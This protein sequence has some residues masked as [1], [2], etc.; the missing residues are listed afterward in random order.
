MKGSLKSKSFGELVNPEGM[1]IL[2]ERIKRLNG[3]FVNI[4]YE[5]SQEKVPEC[6]EDLEDYPDVSDEEVTSRV[7]VLLRT[8]KD[9]EQ[10]HRKKINNI[11]SYLNRRA[12]EG[13]QAVELINFYNERI[14]GFLDDFVY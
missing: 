2:K 8:L 4:A 5:V 6:P 12:A 3:E 10:E 11:S 9:T 1:E 13:C 14:G 7:M